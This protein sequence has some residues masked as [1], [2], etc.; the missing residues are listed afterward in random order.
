MS[1]RKVL[2]FFWPHPPREDETGNDYYQRIAEITSTKIGTVKMRL[3]RALTQLGYPHGA[4]G[5]NQLRKIITGRADPPP[6]NEKKEWRSTPEGAS[7]EY[8]GRQSITS[9]E[10][11]IAFFD[12]DIDKWQIRE[13]QHRAWDV[14]N[15]KGITYT[16]Y[17]T[18]VKLQ[19][20]QRTIEQIKAQLR[21]C[22]D[23]VSILPPPAKRNNRN[24][25]VL[26]IMITDLHMGKL[27]F[28]PNTLEFNWSPQQAADIYLQAISYFIDQVDQ[29][30]SYILLPTGNDL[31]NIN[32]DLNQTKRGTPQMAPDFFQRL[33]TFT[34]KMVFST[35]ENLVKHVAPVHVILVPGNHDEDAVFSLGESLISRFEMSKHVH[36]DNTPILRKWHRFGA[37]LI[38][39][40]HGDRFS[41]KD[42]YKAVSQDR[43]QDFGDTKYRY[44][45][46]GHLHK[47]A[48]SEY[49]HGNTKEE[50]NG[51]EVEICPALT[52][53]DAWHYKNLYIGNLRRAKAFV[54][55]REM[56]KIQEI[57]FNL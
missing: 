25:V 49:W 51:I 41:F 1:A 47:N 42:A 18:S 9:E 2:S 22:I 45:H 23:P 5:V 35:V 52:P 7:I 37:N 24:G 31:L 6:G 36:I 38:G 8:Q 16:N 27:G 26:E 56:G 46:L 15:S 10:E 11:A 33:F 44:L 12:I 29:E 20:R 43:P 48:R 30:V 14:T 32:S 28:N 55:D 53:T 34:R 17:Y 57:Y 50:I 3:S 54:Y 4:R 39:W 13:M 40:D 21:E 19:P